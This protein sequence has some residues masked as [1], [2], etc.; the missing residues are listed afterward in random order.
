MRRLLCGIV[1]CAS[2]ALSGCAG[3]AELYP[4]AD[5]TLRRTAAEFAADAA[6]RSYK[7][8]S[9]R[10]GQALAQAEAGYFLDRL[11][12]T[13]LSEQEWTD[14]EVWINGAYVIFL[15][16]LEPKVVKSLPFQSIYNDAG[17]SFPTHAGSWYKFQPEMI[18]RVELFRDGKLY[19][20]PVRTAE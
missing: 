8:D 20:V 19:D 11:Y 3:R 16:R 17:Q 18:T 1:L 2:V 6:K 12:V 13:N 7:A 9:P 10:G 4:N 5:P 14:V 15:P